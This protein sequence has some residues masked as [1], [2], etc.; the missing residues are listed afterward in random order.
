MPE[1]IASTARNLNLG[2]SPNPSHINYYGARIVESAKN[3]GPKEAVEGACRH[4]HEG[5]VP[6]G[7]FAPAVLA[8]HMMGVGW[9][10]PLRRFCESTP[11]NRRFGANRVLEAGDNM[12]PSMFTG[13]VGQLMVDQVWAAW[14]D[15][16]YI[17]DSLVTTFP[18]GPNLGEHKVPGHSK[19]VDEPSTV[20]PGDEIPRTTYNPRFYIL[21]AVEKKAFI[22]ETT[23][24]ALESDLTG[25]SYASARDIG[26]AFDA[27]RIRSAT[28]N[29]R[30]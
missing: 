6:K 8:Q 13:I 1:P 16:A 23:W 18:A 24:E 27:A 25:Q 28:K 7:A 2:S 11:M 14:E 9:R 22:T 12:T 5:K 30:S 26:R 3:V 4:Y 21:P 19:V 29:A 17:A 20:G 15:P 10:D